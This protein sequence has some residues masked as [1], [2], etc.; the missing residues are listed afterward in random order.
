MLSSVR[1]RIEWLLLVCNSSNDDLSKVVVELLEK[2]PHTRLVVACVDEA[3]EHLLYKQLAGQSPVKI[4]K[5]GDWGTNRCCL[6]APIGRGESHTFDSFPRDPFHVFQYSARNSKVFKLSE[7]G[8]QNPDDAYL[9]D[10]LTERLRATGFPVDRIAEQDEQGWL[11]IEGGNM[12]CDDDFVFVGNIQLLETMSGRKDG[13]LALKAFLN[14]GKAEGHWKH[15]FAVGSTNGDLDLS[16]SSQLSEARIRP[17]CWEGVLPPHIDCFMSLTGV[18]T[19][20]PRP[21]YIIFVARIADVL[22]VQG[23]PSQDLLSLNAHLDRVAA[24]LESQGFCVLRNKVPLIRWGGS[25][26]DSTII[27]FFLNNCLVEV[28][29]NGLNGTAYLPRASTGATDPDQRRLL[30]ALEQE[31]AEQWEG[32]PAEKFEAKFIEADLSGWTYGYGGLHCMTKELL[33]NQHL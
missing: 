4:K 7:P 28:Y 32:L 17:K 31:W 16:S 29:N 5:T 11:K 21:R 13:E 23:S 22:N 12:L 33:R 8:K 6:V 19:K 24:Q 3:M 2:M 20:E 15:I 14:G 10:F 30:E 26:E 27:P 18:R 9:A 1:G 25:G